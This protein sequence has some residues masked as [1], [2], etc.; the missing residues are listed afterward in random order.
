MRCRGICI[1]DYLSFDVLVDGQN[2]A[3]YEIKLTLGGENYVGEAK[4]LLSGNSELKK[5]YFD[6]SVLSEV[7]NVKY[8]KLS[9]RSLSG[10]TDE[11]SL[12]LSNMSLHSVTK[13]SEE[14]QDAVI[15]S[16]NELRQAQNEAQKQNMLSTKHI[17]II[18]VAILFMAVA[19][20]IVAR[21]KTFFNN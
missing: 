20:I 11:F 9:A 4:A 2:G 6:T 7:G 15:E 1:G 19:T 3:S 12:A 14:L 18:S 10:K 21:R 5:L 17:I 16:R 8:I 13:T